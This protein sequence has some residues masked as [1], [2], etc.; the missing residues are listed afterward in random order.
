[1]HDDSNTIVEDT[2]DVIFFHARSNPSHQDRLVEVLV[3]MS[4]L[5][6]PQLTN[7]MSPSVNAQRLWHQLPEVRWSAREHWEAP[8][9][10]RNAPPWETSDRAQAVA[11]FVNANAFIAR[12]H[13]TDLNCLDNSLLALW[14]F[15]SALEYPG[16]QRD[17]MMGLDFFLSG[18]AV[19]IEIAGEQ[20]YALEKEFA[21][22]GNQGRPGLGGPLWDG[23]Y[24]FCGERWALW[25]RRFGELADESELENELRDLS[26]RAEARMKEIEAKK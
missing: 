25:R 3:H 1:M 21:H 6:T 26:A 13:V 10:M 23:M 9:R 17:K 11:N 15:R 12:Q 7:G 19:W 14:T 16:I 8:I 5:P 20:L 22:G 18:A 4:R 24:G 2:W